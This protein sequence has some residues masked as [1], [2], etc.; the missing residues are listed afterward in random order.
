MRPI[1]PHV[2]AL[3]LHRH[4]LLED[5]VENQVVHDAARKPDKTHGLGQAVEVKP[6]VGDD[7]K[8][9][10]WQ[11]EVPAHVAGPLL[12]EEVPDDGE[13]QHHEGGQGAEVDQAADGVDAEL[14]KKR[15][16]G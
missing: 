5:L 15:S 10:E 13:V 2:E 4:V 12:V 3:D 14:L 9:N 11:N 7:Q 8:A 1:W 16:Q 6:H